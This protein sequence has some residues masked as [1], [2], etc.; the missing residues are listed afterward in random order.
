MAI[1]DRLDRMTSWQVDRVFSNKAIIQPIIR[2][3]SGKPQLDSSRQTLDIR[4]VFDQVLSNDFRA[5]SAD[6]EYQFSFDV[7]KYPYAGQIRQGDILILDDDRSFEFL[8]VE[9]DG[10][11]RAVARLTRYE[12]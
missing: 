2:T 10:L 4:G 12:V 1:F 7:V 5:L 11:S 3:E 6:Y 8:T 9:K